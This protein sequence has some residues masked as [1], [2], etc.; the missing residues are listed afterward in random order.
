[1]YRVTLRVY[2]VSIEYK[3]RYII[4]DCTP[5]R[6]SARIVALLDTE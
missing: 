4:F 6:K 2:R 5:Q 1:M 3:V